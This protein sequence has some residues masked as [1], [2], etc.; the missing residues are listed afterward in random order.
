MH[1]QPSRQPLHPGQPAR[2]SDPARQAEAVLT[3]RRQ[4]VGLLLLA[5]AIL[6]LVL[7]RMPPHVLFPAGWWRF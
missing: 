5:A 6:A 3:Q 1:P 4:A 2:L 7:V